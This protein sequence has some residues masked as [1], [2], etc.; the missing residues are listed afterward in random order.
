MPLLTALKNRLTRDL[1][2]EG[3]VLD[4]SLRVQAMV[5]GKTQWVEGPGSCHM[6]SSHHAERWCT[7]SFAFSYP[8]HHH[9]PSTIHPFMQNGSFR[10][11]LSENAL[12][13][14]PGT[15]FLNPEWAGWYYRRCR[16]TG[17]T[18][19]LCRGDIQ[20]ETSASW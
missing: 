8:V 14:T 15:V 11:N 12:V 18:W 16:R 13:G 1:K 4:H 20:R 7:A 2:V 3:Y 10:L 6:A 19:T 9:H 17:G 5:P